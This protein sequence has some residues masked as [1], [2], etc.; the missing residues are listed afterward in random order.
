MQQEKGNIAFSSDKTWTK[1][2][3]LGEPT[4]PFTEMH[5]AHNVRESMSL[6]YKY[7]SPRNQSMN[8]VKE[9]FQSNIDKITVKQVMRAHI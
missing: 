4:M 9:R 2:S 7:Q 1:P 8:R 6:R 3:V 5:T